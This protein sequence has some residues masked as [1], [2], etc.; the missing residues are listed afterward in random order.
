L[1][2]LWEHAG[3]VT[4]YKCEAGNS[5]QAWVIDGAHVKVKDTLS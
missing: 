5:N 2:T 3:L 1:G 4:L